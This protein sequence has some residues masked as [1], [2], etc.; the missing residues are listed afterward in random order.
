MRDMATTSLLGLSGSAVMDAFV[1]AFRVPNLFRR[2]FGEGALA[3]AYVPVLAEALERRRD[4]AWRVTRGMTVWLTMV[5]GAVV[6]VGEAACGVVAWSAAGE[7]RT[8]LLAGLT[9]VMLPYLLFVS[10]AALWAG[11]LQ[12][13][14]H[15][16][17]PALAPTLL[18]VVWLA[19]AWWVAPAVAA[20]RESQAYVLAGAI[21]VAG[22]AQA[23]ALVPPLRA[24]GFRWLPPTTTSRADCGRIV[25]ALSPAIL[26]L[27]VTQLNTLVD[28]LVAW[29]LARPP[30]A[31]PTARWLGGVA[32]PLEQG[33]GAAIYLGERLYQFPLGLLGLAVATVI[34]PALSRHAARGQRDLLRH[35]LTAGLRLVLFLA[36]PAGA[37]LVLLAE[38]IV[39]LFFVGGAF[40]LDDAGRVAA[41]IRMYGLGVAPFCA[42][43]VL[44]RGF[45]AVG[46]LQTPLRVAWWIM[47]LNLAANLALVWP[48]AEAG[49]ALATTLA[50]TAQSVLLAAMLRRS[51]GALDGP[52]LARTAWQ[53]AAATA[54][55]SVAVGGVVA[56]LPPAVERATAATHVGLAVAAALAV[57]FAVAWVVRADELR[58]LAGRF[59]ADERA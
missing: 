34:F 54:A 36:V 18:N 8:V 50:G 51:L 1:L 32:Y 15:F 25:A 4:E 29:V 28:S 19:A 10:V 13:L 55:M 35:D 43:P 52:A 5:L 17:W 33:A 31:G 45:Y 40:T 58:L 53:T 3:A 24:F 37:G 23:A 46:D 21:V 27:A 2:L 42:A 59:A 49:L 6:I 7:P 47:A 26:G 12:A 57:F 14:G 11:T 16:T 38:P 20:E 9:A 44:V 22:L 56:G 39:V 48:L 30:E 41:A